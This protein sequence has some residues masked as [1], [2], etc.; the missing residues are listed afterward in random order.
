MNLLD[1]RFFVTGATGF[2]GASLVRK[3]AGMGCEV[4]ALVRE[5]ADL[6]RLRGIEQKVHLHRGDL[7]GSE[8]HRDVVLAVQPSVIYH[9]ACMEHNPT[10][11]TRTRSFLSIPSERGTS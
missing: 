8:R 3:L 11:P 7:T 5:G 4:H 9:P 2:V 10:K 1:Q 6:W